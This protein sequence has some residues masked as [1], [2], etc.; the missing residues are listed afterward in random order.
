MNTSH[1]NWFKVIL[2]LLLY[3]VECTPDVKHS[4]QCANRCQFGNVFGPKT[5]GI[6]LNVQLNHINIELYF[7]YRKIYASIS[8]IFTK[9]THQHTIES[10]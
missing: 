6:I 9:K 7:R 2:C 1:V 3:C 10:K 5:F 4:K 8:H